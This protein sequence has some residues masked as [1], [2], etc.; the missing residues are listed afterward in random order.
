MEN[1]LLDRI[2]VLFNENGYFHLQPSAIE[3]LK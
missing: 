2:V 1:A 3:E